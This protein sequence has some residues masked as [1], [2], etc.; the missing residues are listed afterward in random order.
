MCQ[1]SIAF[2]RIV[3]MSRTGARLDAKKVVSANYT[4]KFIPHWSFQRCTYMYRNPNLTN[5]NHPLEKTNRLV[6]QKFT[7]IGFASNKQ[8]IHEYNLNNNIIVSKISQLWCLRRSIISYFQRLVSGFHFYDFFIAEFGAFH[9]DLRRAGNAASQ[10][11][12]ERRR[13]E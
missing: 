12:R 1:W 6:Y 9:V 11:L 2:G 8:W 3:T 5:S 13:R 4:I 7:N 10:G